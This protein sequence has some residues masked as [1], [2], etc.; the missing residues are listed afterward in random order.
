MPDEVRISCD[1]KVE[2]WWYRTFDTTQKMEHNLP[3]VV[4][5]DLEYKEWICG[6][7]IKALFS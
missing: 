6:R 5:V 4:V 2:V 3:V 7:A 1:D